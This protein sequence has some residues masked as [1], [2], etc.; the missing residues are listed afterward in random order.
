MGIRRAAA[1]RKSSPNAVDP[2]KEPLCPHR[3]PAGADAGG[4]DQ[5]TLTAVH[6]A[7]TAVTSAAVIP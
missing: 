5:L 7:A 4:V 2:T 6:A 3:R 1:G